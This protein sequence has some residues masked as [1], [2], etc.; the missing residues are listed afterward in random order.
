[1]VICKFAILLACLTVLFWI[2]ITYRIIAYPENYIGF[3]ILYFLGLFI[4]SGLLGIVAW[5]PVFPR[6]AKLFI[7]Y[8]IISMLLILVI[9]YGNILIPYELWLKLGMPE[10]GILI[11]KKVGW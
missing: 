9:Y 3:N 5:K 4:I 7:I 2:L 6:F 11:G 8:N 10:A 1:M